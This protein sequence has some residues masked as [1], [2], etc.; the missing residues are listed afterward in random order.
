M[1]YLMDITHFS[2]NFGITLESKKRLCVYVQLFVAVLYFGLYYMEALRN[3][4]HI[5]LLYINTNLH[6][7]IKYLI[8][9]LII[10][11]IIFYI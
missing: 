8:T 6:H 4:I 10:L 11:N 9:L 2:I 5:G 3:N 1:D 7:V